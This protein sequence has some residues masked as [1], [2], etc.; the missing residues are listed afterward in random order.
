MFVIR[1]SS[2]QWTMTSR[3]GLPVAIYHSYHWPHSI[4]YYWPRAP[5]WRGEGGIFLSLSFLFFVLFSCY[6]Q[7][8]LESPLSVLSLSSLFGSSSPCLLLDMKCA[9]AQS[10]VG[11]VCSLAESS[12]LSTLLTLVSSSLSL[13]LP[14]SL[15]P[16]LCLPGLTI[17]S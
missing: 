7:C 9:Q 13:M 10:S 6:T 4:W 11:C 17:S 14:L 2:W 8:W 1:N 3:F 15:E 5:I 16:F 12:K